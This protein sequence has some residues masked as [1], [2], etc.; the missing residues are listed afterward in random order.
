M[1]KFSVQPV[2]F[3]ES[4]RDSSYSVTTVKQKFSE[5]V[6]DFSQFVPVSQLVQALKGSKDLGTAAQVFYDYLENKP[7]DGD[8]SVPINRFKGLDR[9]EI[10]QAIQSLE[11]EGIPL[12]SSSKKNLSSLADSQAKDNSVQKSVD[13]TN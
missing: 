3:I 13:N 11:K 5:S 8:F 10:S 1:K 2:P 12:S 7:F 6:A 9:A 4:H